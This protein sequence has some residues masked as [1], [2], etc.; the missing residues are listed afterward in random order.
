MTKDSVLTILRNEK[1][2]LSGEKIS[3]LLGVSRAAVNA[4]VKALRE[5]GYD[6]LSATNKGYFLNGVPDCLTEV[7]LSAHLPQQRMQTVLC[8]DCVDSTNNTLRELAVA[9][10]PEGQAVVA[11]EQ[12]RGRGRRGRDFLSPRDKGIYLSILLRPDALPADMTEITAWT[13]VAVSNAIERVCGLRPGIKWVN[14]LVI[15][16]KKVCGILTEMSVESEGGYVQYVIIGIGLN[17]NEAEGEFPEE[18]QNLATSLSM[19]TGAV[20]S[21]ARLAAEMIKELDALRE[22]WPGEKQKYLDAYRENDITVGKEISVVR[23]T[24]SRPGTALAVGEDFSLLVRHPDGT[25]EKISSGEVSIRGIYP[26][27]P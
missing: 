19:E 26:N 12:R 27:H 17:V 10:A 16:G 11:N 1:G 24:E 4:A 21:R 20:Y 25:G 9:G 3:S 7:E 22:A 18:I 15:R 2:Y 5:E 13:A 8:A 6:I 14:D 23:G